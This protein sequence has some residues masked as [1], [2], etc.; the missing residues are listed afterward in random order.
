MA[1]P[2]IDSVTPASATLAPG[3]FVDVVV[4]AHD[5]DSASGIGTFPVT[6]GQGNMTTATVNLT[7]DDPISF[8]VGSSAL[9]VTIQ[10]L[11]PAA[12]NPATYRITAN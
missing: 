7:I 10:R 6:D 8:G 1:A 12:T 4:A 5:P 11:T 9:N 2:V 3:Q